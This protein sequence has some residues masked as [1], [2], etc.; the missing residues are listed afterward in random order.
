[1]KEGYYLKEVIEKGEAVNAI[2]EYESS[3]LVRILSKEKKHLSSMELAYLPFWCY[4]YE[5][6]SAT[7]TDAIIGKV[8]IEPITKT[9]AILPVD[10]PLYPVETDMN[11][12]P[13]CG[14]PDE[15]ATKE[16]IYW[17]AFQ[18]EKKRKSISITFNSSFV[19]YLPF[20]IGY[21]KGNNVGILPVDAITGK[22]DLKLKDAFLKIIDES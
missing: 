11:L 4:E 20:W 18:K 14:E 17:E 12:F 7:L 15:E 19:M 10:Y 21:L 3:F 5:L 2:R 22:V 6:T 13:L 8:A 9:S 1:M 16:A